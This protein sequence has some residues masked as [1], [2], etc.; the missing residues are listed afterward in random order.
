MQV[1]KSVWN[2][3]VKS[4]ARGGGA[5]WAQLHTVGNTFADAQQT[6]TPLNAALNPFPPPQLNCAF[7]SANRAPFN[8]VG[9]N[10]K[11]N[12]PPSPK[13]SKMSERIKKERNNKERKKSRKEQ[14]VPVAQLNPFHSIKTI[15]VTV[16]RFTD[17]VPIIHPS[18]IL[19]G[20]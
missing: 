2:H 9:Q 6:Q 7:K 18:P 19:N 3:T 20:Y 14:G 15:E 11:E 16:C 5:E 4:A 1:A 8:T 13:R 17:G 12:P 10:V